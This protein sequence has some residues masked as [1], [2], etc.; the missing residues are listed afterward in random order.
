VI[1]PAPR[2]AVLAVVGAGLW[3][4]ALVTPIFTV[5]AAVFDAV[6]LGAV[7]ADLMIVRR[8]GPL[9]CTRTCDLVLSHQARAL[10][11][12]TITNLGRRPVTLRLCETWPEGVHP[13]RFELT[14]RVSAAGEIRL[15]YRV[16]PT[17]RGRLTVAPAPVR[18]RGPLDLCERELAA[19]PEHVARV[20]PDLTGVGAYDLVARRSSAVAGR[21]ERPAGG[22]ELETLRE[23]VR[24]DDFRVID[25]K[26]TARLTRPICRELRSSRRQR[27]VLCFDAG[28]HM[29]EETGRGTRFDCAVNAALVL[30]H[31]AALQGDHVGL[32]AFSDRVLRYLKPRHGSGAT[33]VLARALYDLHPSLVE[34]DYGAAF[35]HLAA[36]DRRHA[37]LIVFTHIVSEEV[38]DSLCA[39]LRHAARRHVPVAVCFSDTGMCAHV[40]SAPRSTREV[41]LRAAAL[42][43]LEEQRRA[44]RMLERHGV[45]V[46]EAPPAA[47]QQALVR[48]YLSLKARFVV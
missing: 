12:V 31:V 23:Y 44:R 38:S 3:L 14:G 48:R 18:L 42:E 20:Y 39:H 30:A 40:T 26:A 21:R 5:V 9:R 10:V 46:V 6:L 15:A 22:T 11:V 17:R 7:V 32:L 47:L 25:W 16:L 13:R 41:Y 43:L 8:L 29:T 4:G 24:G 1:L 27:L 45:Q 28:R 36:H 35:R 34:C 19:L 33:P 2:L 37:L